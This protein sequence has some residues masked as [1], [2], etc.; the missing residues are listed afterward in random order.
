MLLERLPDASPEY[1]MIRSY[2]DRV[3]ET[4]AREWL[5]KAGTTELQVL[6]K[7][8]TERSLK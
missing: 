2:L 4:V 1:G 6:L 5:K 8:T 3:G 7:Y